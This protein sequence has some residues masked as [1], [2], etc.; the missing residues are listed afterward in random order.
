MAYPEYPVNAKVIVP[1]LFG[2]V[3]LPG[4]TGYWEHKV[5]SGETLS[6]IAK[7]LF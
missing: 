4:Y 1:V 5:V 7:E 2:P 6:S 3:I